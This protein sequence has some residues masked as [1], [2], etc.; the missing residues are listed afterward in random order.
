MKDVVS[1]LVLECTESGDSLVYNSEETKDQNCHVLGFCSN[2]LQTEH[3]CRFDFAL[4][5][6][7]PTRGA[8]FPTC[9]PKTGVDLQGKGHSIAVN[10]FMCPWYARVCVCGICTVKSSFDV[11]DLFA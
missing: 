11:P 4:C 8:L 7:M 5:A 2:H 9:R 6:I 1:G 10:L 3:K